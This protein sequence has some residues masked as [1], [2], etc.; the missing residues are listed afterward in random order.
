MAIRVVA[1][2]RPRRATESGEDIVVMT[3]SDENASTQPN[4]IRLPN[5]KNQGEAFSFQLHNVYASEAT[6][7]EIFDGESQSIL[8]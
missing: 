2:I 7:Q 3:G 4:L 1:R 8:H 6:Q 5:P